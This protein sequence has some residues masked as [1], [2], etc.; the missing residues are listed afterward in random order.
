MPN[1]EAIIRERSPFL[2]EDSVVFQELVHFFDEKSQVISS[3]Q[4]LREFLLPRRLYKVIKVQGENLMRCAY[5]LIDNH[6]ECLNALGMLRYYRSPGKI[7]WQELEKAENVISNSLTMDLYGWAPDAFTAFENTGD[8]RYEL[9][10]ILA[11][12]F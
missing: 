3:L 7:P 6:P 5:A 11:I 10:A 2:Q 4:D 1:V 9:T 8:E 12:S